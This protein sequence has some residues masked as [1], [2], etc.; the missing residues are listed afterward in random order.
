MQ[1]FSK[2]K[3]KLITNQWKCILSNE[4]ITK[5]FTLYKQKL[6]AFRWNVLVLESTFVAN[7][8]FD[9]K[10][11]FLM[12]QV[13]SVILMR[14]HYVWTILTKKKNVQWFWFSE[15][16]NSLRNRKKW[17]ALEM[18]IQKITWNDLIIRLNTHNRMNRIKT[19]AKEKIN[20]AQTK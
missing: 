12:V 6:Y 11:N 10:T 20:Y 18:K 16:K 19:H 7:K 5:T 2:K 13:T 14:T 4:Q 17:N 3:K 9:Q 15:K 8:F 1:N